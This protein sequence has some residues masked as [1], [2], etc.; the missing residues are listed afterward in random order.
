MFRFLA[1]CGMLEPAVRTAARTAIKHANFCEE[2]EASV[3]RGEGGLLAPGY[4]RDA[5][6][7]RRRLLKHKFPG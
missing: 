6:T 4:N 5:R 3:D 2:L 7:M 1:A